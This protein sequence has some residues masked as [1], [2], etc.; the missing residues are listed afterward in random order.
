MF[1]LSTRAMQRQ[2]QQI[3]DLI[4]STTELW[5]D[6]AGRRFRS[7]SNPKHRNARSP[8]RGECAISRNIL[9]KARMDGS[10][11]AKALAVVEY[12]LSAIVEYPLSAIVEYPLSAIVE[13]PLSA[14]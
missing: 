11:E 13:Y 6:C 8:W 10:L 12:P 9:F 1:R 14:L 4:L 3:Y 5:S 2:D 7:A